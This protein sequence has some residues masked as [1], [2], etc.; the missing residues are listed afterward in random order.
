MLVSG[1]AFD[2]STRRLQTYR[3]LVKHAGIY[4]WFS[5]FRPIHTDHINVVY[6]L[7]YFKLVGC[8]LVHHRNIC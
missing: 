7:V 3:Q 1:R 6:E 5:E 8:L 4:R 2:G